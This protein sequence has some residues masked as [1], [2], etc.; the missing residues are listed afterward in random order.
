[1]KITEKALTRLIRAQRKSYR[2]AEFLRMESKDSGTNAMHEVAW[3]IEDALYDMNGEHTDDLESSMTGKLL[4]NGSME[5]HVVA[6]LMLRRK[7][8]E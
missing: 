3:D 7:C 4:N 6:K 5:D 2:I 8:E 1:M